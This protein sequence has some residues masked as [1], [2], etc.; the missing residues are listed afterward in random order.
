MDEKVLIS[1]LVELAGREEELAAAE[2]TLAHSTD[3]TRDLRDLQAEYEEEAA[4]ARRGD[5]AANVR[6]RGKENEIRAAE[7]E[8]VR[9]QEQVVGLSDRRQFQALQKEIEGL[10]QAVARLED[11]AFALLA[12]VEAAER[13]QQSAEADRERQGGRGAAEA[14]RLDVAATRAL[15]ART[16][17]ETEIARL[18]G[19]L[20]DPV[21][22]QVERLRRGGGQAVVR[23]VG[24]ACGGCCGQLP[25][26][27]A[28]DADKGRSVVRC[29]GCACFVVHRPWH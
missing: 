16:E 2:H 28:I 7:T 5:Q 27:L 25:A 22:R 15:A 18:V 8:L 10:R 24:G 3:R 26:Q 1:L 17:I 19:L 11:E 20:P 13:G 23:V 4:L 9:R 14:E 6:L 29:A 21:R 12:E